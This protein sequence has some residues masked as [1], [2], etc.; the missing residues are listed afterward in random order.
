MESDLYVTVEYPHNGSHGLRLSTG[1]AFYVRTPFQNRRAN[2]EIAHAVPGDFPQ[3]RDWPHTRAPVRTEPSDTVRSARNRRGA[4]GTRK[5]AQPHAARCDLIEL[6]ARYQRAN[7]RPGPTLSR[8]EK[9]VGTLSGH[10]LTGT[11]LFPDYLRDALGSRNVYHRT[12]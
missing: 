5:N 6:Q 12:Y 3:D 2:P 1:T 11:L 4:V 8:P 10:H 7:P 9:R